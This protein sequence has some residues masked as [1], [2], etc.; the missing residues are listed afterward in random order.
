MLAASPAAPITPSISLS[1][2]GELLI[3]RW[4]GVVDGLHFGYRIVVSEEEIRRANWDF[5]AGRIEHAKM[6]MLRA[7]EKV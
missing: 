4:D 1:Y 2:R 3:L 6:E 7:Y 5:M